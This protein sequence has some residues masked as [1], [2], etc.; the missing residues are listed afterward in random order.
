MADKPK[1]VTEEIID[2]LD[3]L[4]RWGFD[5]GRLLY[6]IVDEFGMSNEDAGKVL[7]YWRKT[8][9]QSELS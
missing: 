1:I 5:S 4:Q 2:Y 8:S 7:A 9:G 3:T 6:G